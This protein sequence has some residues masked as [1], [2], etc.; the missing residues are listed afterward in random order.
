MR[1]L[2]LNYL[3]LQLHSI[4]PRGYEYIVV[5]FIKGEKENA[6]NCTIRLAIF[7]KEEALKWLKEFEETSMTTWNVDRTHK[8]CTPR[9]IFKVCDKFLVF[10]N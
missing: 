4:L 7:E 9:I 1:Y 10:L 5:E 6:F 3:I 8:E 2:C